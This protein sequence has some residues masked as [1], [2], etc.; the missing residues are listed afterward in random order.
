VLYRLR[1]LGLPIKW[2]SFDSFQSVDSIQL[3]AHKQFITG[4]QSMDTT[5]LPYDMLKTALHDGRV[6]APE[7]DKC[8]QELVRLERDPKSGKIDHP[9]QSSKD[10]SDAM[11]GVCYGLTMRREL[12]TR[13]KVPLSQLPRSVVEAHREAEDKRGL[14]YVERTKPERARIT[15]D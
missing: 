14:S 7:H 10:I 13:H 5:N 9:P 6:L 12:W 8:R 1:E 3:L 11:A 2:V 4:T 15:A